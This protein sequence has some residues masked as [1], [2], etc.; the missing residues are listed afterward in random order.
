M[1]KTILFLLLIFLS[2]SING[3]TIKRVEVNGVILS[4]INDVEAVT[5]FNKS[6][7]SGTITNKKGEFNIKVALNDIIEISALQ[8]QTVAI[9]IE[10]DVV[11]SKQLKIQLV[12]QVN[13]LD[14]VTLTSGLTGNIETDITNIKTVKVKTIDMGNMDVDFEYNDDKAFDKITVQNHLNATLNPEARDYLPDLIKIFNLFKSKNNTN[15]SKNRDV[16]LHSEIPKDLLSVYTHNSISEAFNIPTQHVEAFLAYVEN[17]G[18]NPKL[19]QPENEM[20][21]IAF[22]L[23]Q[24]ELFLKQKNAKN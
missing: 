4:K 14:A 9:A 21:L 16:L 10:E 13:Q 15:K 5:V 1:K 11:K 24:S 2:L 8:F 3:Q 18:V 12:E 22:L 19:L 6:S 23:K 17:K 20:Q 7:N